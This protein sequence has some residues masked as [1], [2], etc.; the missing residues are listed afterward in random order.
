MSGLDIKKTYFEE[1]AA[2]ILA[3]ANMNKVQF[4]KEMDV[5]PQNINKFIATKNALLLTKAATVLNTTIQFLLYDNS[6]MRRLYNVM[7]TG[8]ST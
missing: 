2:E 6:Q 7:C 3:A 4:A 8:V 5:L 1:H